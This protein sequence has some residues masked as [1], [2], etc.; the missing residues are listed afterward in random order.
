M[1]DQILEKAQ[2][3]QTSITSFLQ[4]LI[5]IPSVNGRDEE[6]EVAQRILEEAKKLDLSAKIAAKDQNR[7]N[8]LVTLGKGEKGFALIGH[9]DTVAEGDASNWTYPPFEAVSLDGLIFG[10]GSAD[11]KA[12]IACGLYTLALLRDLNLI[13]SQLFKITLAGVADEESGASSSLGVRFLLDE[14]LLKA[15][16]AIYTYTS[17]I[18][19]I[20]HRGLIR[21][22]ITTKGESVHA[23]LAEWHNQIT[24]ANAVTALSEILYKLEKLKIPFKAPAGFEHL[25]FTI[26]PGT[27]V[28]GGDYPSIIPNRAKATID[29]RMLPGQESQTVFR[30]I[31][32]IIDQVTKARRGITAKTVTTINFPGAAI[33]IDHPL[34]E[35]A[36]KTAE[37]FTGRDWERKGAGPGNEGY[38]LIGAGIPTLYGF[39]PR[40]GNPHAP[41]EWVAIDSLPITTAIYA[42]IITEYLLTN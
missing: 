31:Q 40:G 28:S 3:Y 7:P 2:S 18:V 10:R 27:L 5:R 42:H 22:E 41:N 33:P 32:T 21:L 1:H 4:E 37:E 6:R 29:I 39:G 26:T 11:N 14:Q 17:D 38:M 20:G 19:C 24:G 34:A 23:G 36:Q 12:G 35:I 8:V 16:G 9:L 13:D 25:G 15:D 30:E